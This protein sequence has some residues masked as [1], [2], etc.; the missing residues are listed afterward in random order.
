MQLLYPNIPDLLWLVSCALLSELF[1]TEWWV[2]VELFDKCE[3]WG[4]T[5]SWLLAA[6]TVRSGDLKLRGLVL[7]EGADQLA[8]PK[9]CKIILRCCQF[10][11]S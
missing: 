3:V 5:G 8:T 9:T 11:G 4:G 7:Q 1:L 10:V 6:R 2:L